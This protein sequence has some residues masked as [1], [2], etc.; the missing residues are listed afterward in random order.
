MLGEVRWD[1][2][3]D[4]SRV[5]GDIAA[6]RLVLAGEAA[7]AWP[8]RAAANLAATAAEYLTEEQRMLPS[9]SGIDEFVRQVDTLREAVERLEKR[10]DRLTRR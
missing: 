9:R 6:R 7:L 8:R 3:E 5:V 10:I 1:A 4:L 2:E